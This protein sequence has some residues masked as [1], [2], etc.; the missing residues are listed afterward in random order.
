VPVSTH[1]DLAMLSSTSSQLED[2]GV[3]ITEMA[4]RYGA[5]P[6]S[7]L[8]SE[9]YGAERSL[10]GARRALDRARAFLTETS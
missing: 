7:A 2:L 10:I 6:D 4:E 1:S 3:R 8:A 9:L 5:T